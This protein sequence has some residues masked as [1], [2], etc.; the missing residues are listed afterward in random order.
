VIPTG[1]TA[2][3]R[4]AAVVTCLI[5]AVLAQAVAT[6][7][8]D[9][10]APEILPDI[11]PP[12][13]W[14]VAP[15]PKVYVEDTLFGYINGESVTFFP[16]GFEQLTVA[17]VHPEGAPEEPIV[18][19]LY[20][21]GSPLDAFGIY[22]TYRGVDDDFIDVGVEGF[23]GTTQVVFF[24]D[25]YFVKLHFL[26]PRGEKADLLALSRRVAE[27][28]PPAA[29]MPGGLEALQI[30]GVVP[31]SVVYRAGSVMGYDF[32]PKG[33]QATVQRKNADDPDA[34]PT[35][36]QVSVIQLASP[37]AA[38]QALKKVLDDLKE[39][40]G[41]FE[42]S[43]LND[44]PVTRVTDPAF[45][46]GLWAQVGSRLLHVSTAPNPPKA[47]K[48]VLTALI[49]ANTLKPPTNDDAS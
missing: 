17:Q 29:G 3:F 18:V 43:A 36:Y 5:G 45:D 16:Y 2:L 19:Q 13:G 48:P 25:R 23:I 15:E 35:E 40:G 47:G 27:A 44:T 42:P 31:R 49:K 12:D 6:A 28:L 37:D 30:P 34:T 41:V 32:L 33:F 8:D 11:Q 14:V 38:A 39:F 46:R 21:M 7:S 4:Y 9:A 1:L 24:Q 10:P 26:Q 22:S 20:R